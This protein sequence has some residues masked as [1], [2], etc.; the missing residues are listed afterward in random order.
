MITFQDFLEK[1]NNDPCW[2]AY[3]QLGTKKKGKKEVPNCIPESIGSFVD[4]C[5]IK[6]IEDRVRD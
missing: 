3:K 4:F 5:R 6:T 1:K 2:K